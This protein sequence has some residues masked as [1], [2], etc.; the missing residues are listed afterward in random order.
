MI[1]IIEKLNPMARRINMN[2]HRFTFSPIFIKFFINV[3]GLFDLIINDYN[4][5]E[6]SLMLKKFLVCHHCHH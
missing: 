4:Q 3:N 2:R 1:K 5:P 6:L